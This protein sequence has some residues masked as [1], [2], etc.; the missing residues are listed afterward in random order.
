MN[1]LQIVSKE[2]AVALVKS[3]D[4]VFIQ[5][6]AMTPKVLVDALSRRYEELENVEIISIHTEGEALYTQPPYTKAFKV[7]SAFVGNP[8]SFPPG[9]SSTRCGIYTGFTT[10]CTWLL[11]PW[12]VS[13]RHTSRH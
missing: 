6:A 11:F 7:N 2:E 8:S 5:G 9:Y 4:R 12:G 10:R 13:R 3:N 1:Q